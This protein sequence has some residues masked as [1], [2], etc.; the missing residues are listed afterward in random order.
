VGNLEWD[1]RL[2]GPETRLAVGPGSG[3]TEEYERAQGFDG[4][5]FLGVLRRQAKLIAA[6]VFVVCAAAALIVFQLT[7]IY[8]A[9]ALIIVDPRQQTI[10]DPQAQMSLTPGDLGRVE[11]EVEIVGSPSV[12]LKVI[13]ERQLFKDPDFA[14]GPGWRDKLAAVL[15]FAPAKPT[16]EDI[17]KLTLDNLEKSVSISRVG[18]TYLINVTVRS[19]DPAKAAS[20][21]NAIAEAYI[22]AQI[23]AK[24]EMVLGIQHA[25]ASRLDEASAA[26]RQAEAAVDAFIAKNIDSIADDASRRDLVDLRNKIATRSTEAGRLSK[27]LLSAQSEVANRDWQTLVAE[28][29]SETLK[30]LNDQRTSVVRAI[31]EAGPNSEK[32]LDLRSSLEK[33]DGQMANEAQV[34]IERVQGDLDESQK[35]EQDLRDQLRQRVVQTDLP[36]DLLAQ[37]YEIQQEANVS[38]SIYQDLLARSKAVEAQTNVQVPDSRI[39]SQA[40]PPSQ[41]SFPKKRLVLG[42][43]GGFSLALGLGLAFLRER[44][45]GG[46]VSESQAEHVLS[47]P[48]VSSPPRIAGASKANAV[49]EGAEIVDRPLSAYSEA[50]R[51]LRLGLEFGSQRSSEVASRTIMVTSAMPNEGKTQT[52]L[53]LARSFAIAGRKTLL[54]DCDL[55]RPSLH[56]A[57]GIGLGVGLAD[58][59]ASDNPSPAL[60]P[61]ITQDPRTD[62]SLILGFR[63]VGAPT[64]FLFETKRFATLLERAREQF[65]C[66]IVDSSPVL[67]VVDP[68]L[69]L[70]YAT[71]VVLVVRWASTSQREVGTALA[72]ISRVNSRK[73]PIVAVLNRSEVSASGYGS[74][75]GSYYGSYQGGAE[76]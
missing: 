46:F 43:A 52:A 34:A 6:T 59:L 20:I 53:S 26:R 24:V 51:R 33:L 11:S 42:L 41:P 5:A 14:P 12:L 47:I 60:G 55:R 8:S 2:L 66:I 30:S 7:P 39:V 65:D 70:R 68:R 45:I 32:A 73:V 44:Y 76:A 18:I 56:K 27:I 23:S 35:A 21:A 4:R 58:Y 38:R 16:S 36:K 1:K 15:G 13:N 22:A 71:S 10:L 63:G 9:T 57:L 3:A 37:L 48:V 74:V 64:D 62:L 19:A 29:D 50:I 72:D 61:F 25:L 67:P 40:L 54:I 49:A 28:V 69:L 75:Y 17:L 31:E